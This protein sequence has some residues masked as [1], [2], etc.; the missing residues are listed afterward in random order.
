VTRRLVVREYDGT[1]GD[2]SHITRSETGL[3]P[4]AAVALLHGVKGERP[5]EHRNRRGAAWD[6]FKASVAAD[7]MISPIFVTVDYGQDP[8]I[9]EGSHRRDAAVELGWSHLPGEVRYF[10]HAETQGTVGER[11]GL[12]ECLCW[13]G[14]RPR[15]CILHC[16]GCIIHQPVS[17][18]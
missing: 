3:I 6:A 17:V 2:L 4:V 15:A 14:V 1:V 18:P 10:G 5:G 9:S 8:K 12:P 16:C 11:A 13:C 7:G